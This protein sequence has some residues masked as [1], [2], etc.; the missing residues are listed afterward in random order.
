MQFPAESALE[1]LFGD[2]WSIV[3]SEAFETWNI[4]IKP[5]KAQK[6]WYKCLP[7]DTLKT[8]KS[9]IP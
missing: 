1:P 9:K 2:A 7:G 8:Q 5:V 3:T 6:K 4:Y